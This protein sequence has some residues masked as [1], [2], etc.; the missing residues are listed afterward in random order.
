MLT[1]LLA[2][3]NRSSILREVLESYCRLQQPSGGWK[4]VVIDN[5]STD[6]TA[7]I[8]S[9]FAG[10]LPVQY[11]FE[12]KAGKNNALNTGLELLE[13]DLAVF[14]D[15]DA[16]PHPDWLVALRNA[17]DTQLAYSM[18]GGAIV[19]RWEAP[20]PAWIRWVELGPTYTLT[21]PSLREGPIEP[22]LVFGPNMAIR[23]NVLQ[24][25]V[26]FD[27]SMGPR[28]SNYPMG[29][30]TELVLR[31]SRQGHRA[32]HVSGAVV[33]HF[34]CKEQLRKAWVLQRSLRYGRGQYRL[35]FLAGSEA[36]LF[37][38]IPRYLYVEVFKK[39][40]RVMI[41]LASLRQEALLRSLLLFNFRRGQ[42]IEARVLA[43]EQ[44]AEHEI[45][46]T[47]SITSP[48]ADK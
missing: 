24:S 28:G 1:M 11:V 5:G 35:A 46:A 29:S 9:S 20:P 18:F 3:R 4:L 37:M 6:D 38:G 2:T 43:R 21:D 44:L 25:G 15:D 13:G 16:F 34:I 14:T 47:T 26:R 7:Q 40:G 32:R 19:P 48:N 33:E 31:L 23:T 30:E 42:M 22:V 12:E 27:P 8:V 10:R 45:S 36:G 17:A 41:A 39:A